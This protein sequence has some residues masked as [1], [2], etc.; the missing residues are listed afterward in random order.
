ML[1]EASERRQKN[2]NDSYEVKSVSKV[3]K[4]KN[5]CKSETDKKSEKF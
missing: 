3:T 5:Q 2:E 4:P 1:E